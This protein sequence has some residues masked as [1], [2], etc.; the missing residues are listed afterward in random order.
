MIVGVDYSMSCPAVCILD[1]NKK[2]ANSKFMFLSN[3][4][5][6]I[7][8]AQSNI[9]SE[10]HKLYTTEQ[11]R[12]DHISNSMIQFITTNAVNPTVYI[13][14]YAM[15]AKG[16]V[17]SIAENTGLFKHK[18]HQLGIEMVLFAP[19]AIK[20]HA[21]G[22]GN[23]DK[24]AMYKAFLARGDNPDLVKFYYDKADAQVKSPVSDIVDAY[25][26]ALM[27]ADLHESS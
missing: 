12:F 16:K 22:K 1:P 14:D 7:N 26:I 6:D 17:F 15:G 20:K 9:H 4:K 24:D 19:T 2:F 21:T 27:G 11:E 10:L 13:E 8:P 25:F 3:R 18:L 5:R 23:S